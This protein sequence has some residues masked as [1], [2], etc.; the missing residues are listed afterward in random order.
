MNE[1]PFAA[2]VYFPSALDLYRVQRRRATVVTLA[3]FTTLAAAYGT[4]SALTYIAPG[5]SGPV[6]I[7]LG[8][9]VCICVALPIVIWQN[10]TM[11]LYALFVGGL[12][13]EG[14]NRPYLPTTWVPFWWNIS[15]IGQKDA[16]TTLMNAITLSPAEVLILLTALIWVVRS[17]ANR[18]FRFHT[19]TFFLPIAAYI[20]M[21]IF[22]FFHGLAAHGDY[23][24]ALYE[25]RPQLQ[26][27]AVY[28]LA[29]NLIRK[30]EEAIALVWV[31]VVCVAA[32]AVTGAAAFF[33]LGGK[34]T[35]QGLF[36]H[37]TSLCFNLLFLIAL[38]ALVSGVDRKL[39][40]WSLLFAPAALV[41]EFANQ[42]RAGIAAF[43]IALI[44]L[45]PIA[46]VLF[47]ERRRQITAVGVC[48]LVFSAVY[49]PVAWNSSG[50]WALPARS[51]KSQ[52]SPDP[53]DASSDAYRLA[54]NADLKMTR[55]QQPLIGIGYGK[56][57]SQ[58]IPLVKLTT[59]FLD[60]MP[61]N[62]VLWVWMRLGHI[63]FFLFMMMFA[64]FLIKG[65]QMLRQVGDSRL[66]L[67][68]IL[69]VLYALMIFV[70]GKYDL[71][72]ANPRQ[73]A[74]TAV[75]LGVL[76]ILDRLDK[77]EVALD[78]PIRADS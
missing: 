67:L 10:P 61:H 55:D 76:A 59:D 6:V 31:V 3:L 25:V 16:G 9:T 52:I 37:D 30:R 26:F 74:I 78:R 77:P 38:T 73:M 64:A 23:K 1:E 62:S 13:F 29:V 69:G 48:C 66:K 8:V 71:Q 42:R 12:L 7:A 34:V 2:E 56:P 60:Y 40:A 63:G 53:R 27:F 19:G 75:L 50:I 20:S 28:L 46:A 35:D 36:N 4:M 18:S 65:V 14:G 33:A 54:E 49:L 24:M 72:F 15:S 5:V 11:G 22:G 43:L 44:P 68:G 51:L 17:I 47:R 45:L 57:F 58:R 39:C 32:Q 21:V 41:A 70:Y